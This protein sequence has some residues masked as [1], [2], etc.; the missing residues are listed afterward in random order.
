[1]TKFSNFQLLNPEARDVVNELLANA[2]R[3]RSAF[4]SFMNIWMGFN[5]WMA[6]VTGRDTD[7]DMLRNFIGEK[8]LPSLLRTWAEGGDDARVSI[9]HAGDDYKNPWPGTLFECFSA[10]VT[11]FEGVDLAGRGSRLVKYSKDIFHI[12]T[13]MSLQKPVFS[14]AFK[15]NQVDLE[16]MLLRVFP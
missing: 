3:Q 11:G 2:D 12:S 8:R 1:M 5:G 16:H 6:T 4:M 7:A 9:L 15:K 13:A 14:G 10:A